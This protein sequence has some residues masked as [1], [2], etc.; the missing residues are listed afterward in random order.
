MSIPNKKDEKE[1]KIVDDVKLKYNS[2]KNAKSSLVE[3]W[4]SFIGAYN[5]DTLKQKLASYKSNMV[6]NHIFATIETIKPILLSNNP[7]FQVIPRM[8]A[9]FDKAV[10]AQFALDYEWKRTKMNEIIDTVVTNSLILGTGILGLFWD[11]SKNNIGEIKPVEISPFNFFPDSNAKKLEECEYV[12]YATYKNISEI[13][14]NYPDKQKEILSSAGY[15][16]EQDLTVG[17]SKDELKSNQILYMECYMKDYSMEEKIEQEEEKTFRVKKRKYPNGRRIIIAGDVL[18]SDGEN[19]YNDNGEFPFVVFKCYNNPYSFWG[20]GEVKHILSPQFELDNLYNQILDTAKLTANSPWILDKNSGIEKGQ[21]T[22]RPGLI[23]RKNPGTEVRREQPAQ[24]PQYMFNLLDNLK[25]DIQYIS[26]V[27][28]VT[29]G[30][31]VGSI[32]SGTGISQLLET[33]QS[34]IKKKTE[35]LEYSLSDLGS[36]WLNRIIQFWTLPRQIR[37][38]VTYKDIQ[39]LEQQGIDLQNF[40]LND[41]LLVSNGNTP[42]FTTVNGSDLDGAWEVEVVSGSTLP[43][44]KMQRLQ[45]IIQLA[46]TPAE[47][48]LP[49]LDRQTILE[50]SELDN[51]EEILARFEAMR[52]QKSQEAQQQEQ[53]NMQKSLDFNAQQQQ[54]ASELEMQKTGQKHAMEMEKEQT[55]AK[56]NIQADMM[57]NLFNIMLNA[58]QNT[59]AGN[60]DKAKKGEK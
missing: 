17:G 45:Q 9:E 39:N 60:S 56:A 28:D 46:Q 35:K 32:T 58:N 30:G 41:T 18:L 43:V 7:K 2:S 11:G 12:I 14:K 23:L 34:R 55:K 13:I 57:K 21:I 1:K 53:V 25:Y 5:S 19:P 16:S 50:S 52:N 54:I 6:E 38:M 44:N 10:K 26:G 47:D 8:E 22:N 42:I 37:V 15:P 27:F 48:G 59:S 49:M 31:A 20:I 33:S 36:M 4:K 29:R 51:V 40:L 24:L 3:E